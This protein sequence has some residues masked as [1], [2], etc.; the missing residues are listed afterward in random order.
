MNYEEKKINKLTLK[1]CQS[2]VRKLKRKNAEAFE[3]IGYIE[4]YIDLN[5]G[6]IRDIQK[7]IKKLKP[8]T[9]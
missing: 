4:D 9:P 7:R 6:T 3:E 1:E 5:K 8:T 2:T